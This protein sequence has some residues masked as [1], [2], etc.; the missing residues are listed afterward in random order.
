MNKLEETRKQRRSAY[1]QEAMAKVLGVCKPTYARKE[2]Q[3]ESFTQRQQ[4]V[5]ADYL[6][7]NKSEIFLP[8]NSN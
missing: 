4:E 6:G 2:K 7:V 8:S 5:I 3:P 1:S